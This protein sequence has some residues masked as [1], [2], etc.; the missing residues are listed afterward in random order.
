MIHYVN[1]LMF[2]KDRSK[3]AVVRKNRGPQ[4]LIGK[5]NAIGGKIE[6]GE[7]PEDAIQREFREETGVDHAYW[8]KVV[9]LSGPNF[10]VHFYCAFTD[11]VFN[12]ETK[13][14]EAIRLYYT[15]DLIH[16]DSLVE[17]MKVAIAIA[18]DDSG[19]VKPVML[20]DAR[21]AA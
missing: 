9:V 1:G 16:H 11:A 18:L 4:H 14:S 19:I 15:R 5:L 20:Q 7:S 12:V 17:N 10:V 8:Q 3:M 2:S 6:S 13:E 21:A